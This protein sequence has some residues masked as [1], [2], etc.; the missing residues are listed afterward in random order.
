MR[1]YSGRF[2][3]VHSELGVDLLDRADRVEVP[4]WHAQDVRG[5]EMLVSHELQNVS[6][7]SEIPSNMEETQALVEPQ[8]PWAERHF[9][10][11][12]SGEPLNPPPSAAEWQTAGV[13]DKHRKDFGGET[14][15]YSHTY[16]E[17]F[18]PRRAGA[19]AWT[20]QGY[21][22]GGED[23][24]GIRFRYGDLQD[25]VTLLGKEPLTRQAYLPVWFPEDTGAHHGERVPCSLGY[26]FM[27]RGE[28]ELSVT[29]MIRSVDFMRHFRD[30]VY[31]AMRLAQW[32]DEQLGGGF[33]GGTLTMHIMSLHYFE[34]DR[35]R[36]EKEY[37][38]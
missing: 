10:E 20:D 7:E 30:D 13:A 37:G 9:Q 8:L 28:A 18:W 3:A 5:N 15:Q 25:V 16:P 2:D 38:Y 6:F 14:E 35:K 12:I 34:G 33:G 27:I 22:T 23:H 19:D 26:H 32:I 17:R 1:A 31:L 24:F 36:M 4:T 11:R 29:Y 21:V